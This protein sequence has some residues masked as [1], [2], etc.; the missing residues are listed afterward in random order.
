MSP[1][2][3]LNSGRPNDPQSW[4]R[5]AYVGNNPLRFT[6]PTGLYKFAETC[7]DGDTEC[8]ENQ[9]RFVQ[10]LKDLREA[11]NNLEKGS[12]ERKQLEKSLKKIGEEEGKGATI[13][14][15]DIGNANGLPTLGLA[16]LFTNTITFN[17][18]AIN[19]FTN[20]NSS[21][22]SGEST[23][24]GFFTGVIGH[25]GSHLAG[26]IPL[27]GR[28]GIR[29]YFDSTTERGALRTESYIYQGLRMNDPQYRWLWN[30]EWL[31]LDRHVIE[32][33][34]NVGVNDLLDLIR[35]KKDGK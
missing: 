17:M 26:N 4:N 25:E 23:A 28:I 14:F 1:D 15:G 19:S 8:I 11:T 27:L 20:T 6:D 13:K 30:N 12:K 21:I 32:Q 35:G 5:Y 3:L 22:Q 24:A 7:K 18:N 16:N 9:E 10:G 31:T 33:R 2:P 29:N 34:R